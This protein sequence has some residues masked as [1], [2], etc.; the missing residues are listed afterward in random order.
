MKK[1]MTLG[2]LANRCGYFVGNCAE[3]CNNGY[4]C[5]HE[6]NTDRDPENCTVHASCQD[7]SCPI[8]YRYDNEED[9]GGGDAIMA[10]M[11]NRGDTDEETRR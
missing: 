8:A 3:F 2:D 6:K 5:S 7:F 10:L 11:D 9:R 4:G 1:T